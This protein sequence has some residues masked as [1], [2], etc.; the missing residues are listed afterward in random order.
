[1]KNPYKVL[2]INQDADEDQI[3]KAFRKLA[4]K[5]HPDKN[6]DDPDAIKKF[7]EINE[8]YEILSNIKSKT[9]FDN[10]QKFG[11][12]TQ[13]KPFSSVYE[14][15]IKE[16]F[17]E[18]TRTIK[19]GDDI[20]IEIFVTLEEVLKGTE[21]NVSFNRNKLC[22]VCNGIGRKHT[23]CSYCDG[24]GIRIIN[25][26]AGT[27][28]AFCFACNG[29]GKIESDNCLN[30][31]DGFEQT[32]TETVGF[33][34]PIG[35]S[36]GTK[37]LKKGFGNPSKH[38]EGVS[39]DLILIVKIQKHDVFELS[40]NGNVIIKIPVSYSE[41]LLGADIEVPTLEGVVKLKIPPNTSPDKKLRLKEKGIPIIV[42][43]N[44][45]YNRGDQYVHLKLQMPIDLND[46]QKEIL[47]ELFLMEQTSILT[48]R[49]VIIEKLGEQNG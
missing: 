10:K 49:K 29:T 3:R 41:L 33:S 31:N 13:K 14:D 12:N 5:Y 20:V 26:R 35:V 42:D 2:E 8:A 30:C 9:I 16:F 44:N 40:D 21:I 19:K 37:F 15:I 45:I 17:N 6:P 47:Q 48:A 22:K 11:R 1:L 7:K 27:V 46:R 32:Y 38:P 23:I 36:N 4:V 25:K 43:Q 18:N 39:G 34:V 28:Q 24:A